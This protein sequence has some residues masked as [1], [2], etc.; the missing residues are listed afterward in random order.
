MH[1][2]AL[3]WCSLCVE[4]GCD[5]IDRFTVCLHGWLARVILHIPCAPKRWKTWVCTV[6]TWE[7]LFAPCLSMITLSLWWNWHLIT[8]LGRAI[9]IW[10]HMCVIYLWLLWFMP[11]M[12]IHIGESWDKTWVTL[13]G[14]YLWYDFCNYNCLHPLQC[15]KAVLQFLLV[16]TTKPKQ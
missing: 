3:C 14:F 15:D 7:E 8:R 1:M 12:L 13:W 16:E 11:T 2:S 10:P 5:T 4:I 6:Y 9:E